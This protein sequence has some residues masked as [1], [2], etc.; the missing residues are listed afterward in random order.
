V[1]E[2]GDKTAELTWLL[3]AQPN[4]VVTGFRLYFVTPENLTDYRTVPFNKGD[5]QRITY[6]LKGISKTF[7]C[8]FPFFFR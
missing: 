4:G 3:P 8:I 7:F 5:P 1:V 2:V 6:Q